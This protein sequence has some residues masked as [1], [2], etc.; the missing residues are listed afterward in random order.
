[1]RVSASQRRHVA[2]QV[3]SIASSCESARIWCRADA[4]DLARALTRLASSLAAFAAA[5][6]AIW[7]LDAFFAAAVSFSSSS[8]TRRRA[9]LASCAASTAARQAASEARR[10]VAAAAT[11]AL[12]PSSTSASRADAAASSAA[13][14]SAR[15]SACS[16]RLANFATSSMSACSGA[17]D[18]VRVPPG[19]PGKLTVEVLFGLLL[20]F[21]RFSSVT[22]ASSSA[23]RCCRASMSCD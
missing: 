4:L 9:S 2:K 22:K 16:A 13:S 6:S 8:S 11:F 20:L 3:A 10:L 7:S 5:A 18:G 1:M 19:V 23:Q 15:C 12:A 17:V 21:V 14:T